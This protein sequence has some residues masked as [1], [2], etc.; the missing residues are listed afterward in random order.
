VNARLRFTNLVG[1]EPSE[2]VHLDGD[3]E[4]SDR[5]GADD[6]HHVVRVL[7]ELDLE[8]LVRLLLPD[9]ERLDL[10]DKSLEPRV[11]ARRPGREKTAVL[12]GCQSKERE[13]EQPRKTTCRHE[14]QLKMVQARESTCDDYERWHEQI[15]TAIALTLVFVNAE[16]SSTSN[17]WCSAVFHASSFIS[18][19]HTLM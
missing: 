4:R 1:A 10:K 9:L 5:V 12:D 3:G 17:V 2:G 11:S 19:S 13:R 8:Q 16:A 18:I 6:K 15:G 14:R 7:R